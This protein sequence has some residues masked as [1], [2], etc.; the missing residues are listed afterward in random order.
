MRNVN[1]DYAW[2][3]QATAVQSF[4]KNKKKLYGLI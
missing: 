3:Q 4:Q 2:L 1:D